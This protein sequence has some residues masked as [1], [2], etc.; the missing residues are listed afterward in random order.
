[1]ITELK[2]IKLRD[3]ISLSAQISE[4][5]YKKWLIVTHGL[6]EHS[7]RHSYLYDLFSQYFNICIY[8]LRGHGKSGGKKAYVEN[9]KDFVKDLDEVIYYLKDNFAMTEYCLFGHSMGGLITAS[10]M[11]N[12]VEKDF[13]PSKVFLS[14]PAVAGAGTLGQAFKIAPSKVLGSLKSIPFSV[15]VAGLLDLSGLSHDP[16]VYESYILDELNMLKVHTKLFLELLAEAKDVFSR[17]LRVS[18]DLYCSIGMKD[19]IVDPS[20]VIKYFTQIEK[21]AQLFKIQGSFH[22]PH[23][24]ISKYREPYFEYLKASLLS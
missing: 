3:G 1:M 24:E 22:E 10:F 16:R 17:P 12:E 20:S 4:K 14:S 2:N 21:N 9:F 23:N 18:C 7:G 5:G 6:G 19:K 8:D 15:P 13:Y 11:Q